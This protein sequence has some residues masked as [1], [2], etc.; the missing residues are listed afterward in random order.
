MAGLLCAAAAAAGGAC[1]GG[2]GDGD[3]DGNGDQARP[4]PLTTAEVVRA[5]N[6][7][8]VA[9]D[10]QRVYDGGADLAK[11]L[12]GDTSRAEDLGPAIEDKA[13]RAALEDA[14]AAVEK[15]VAKLGCGEP[16]CEAFAKRIDDVERGA[17]EC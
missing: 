14:D 12:L 8:R 2:D 5:T 13:L 3:G 11:R 9:R 1:G 17:L 6:A 16:P 7:I 15:R 4:R 10:C